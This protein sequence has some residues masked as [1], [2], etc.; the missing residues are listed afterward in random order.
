MD[1]TGSKTY[2]GVSYDEIGEWTQYY[3]LIWGDSDGVGSLI[4]RLGLKP[5]PEFDIS[6]F[7]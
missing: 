6:E 3:H 4:E 5:L 2:E 1:T 7:Y